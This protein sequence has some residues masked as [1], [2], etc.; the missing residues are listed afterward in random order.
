MNIFSTAI[1]PVNLWTSFLDY[2]SF[3][4]TMALILSRLASI[5]FTGGDFLAW[6]Y[7]SMGK[8]GGLSPP[9]VDRRGRWSVV[10]WAMAD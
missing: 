5:P 3:M 8:Y 2:G 9:S 7:F 4:Y 1:M 6:N 10:D